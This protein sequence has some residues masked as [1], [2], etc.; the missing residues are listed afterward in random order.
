MLHD[1]ESAA[2]IIERIAEQGVRCLRAAAQI[3]PAPP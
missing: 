1:V 2:E 3:D